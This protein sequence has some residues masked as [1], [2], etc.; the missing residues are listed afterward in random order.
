[1]RSLKLIMLILVPAVLLMLL[2]GDKLLLLFGGAYSENAA[3][4]LRIL[5][6]SALPLSINYIYFGMRRVEMQMRIVILL[7]LLI[8]VATLGLSFILLPEMGIIGA[9]VAWFASQGAVMAAVIWRLW[10]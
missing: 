5:A 1:M 3:W 7:S 6:L 2:V 4:L 8:A 9:G 10:R